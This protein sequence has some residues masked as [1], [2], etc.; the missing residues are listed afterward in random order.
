[1]AHVLNSNIT[2][3]AKRI[4]LFTRF[5]AVQ[6]LAQALGLAAG[7]IIVRTLDKGDYALYTL[8]ISG[9][10]VGKLRGQF[11]P[12]AHRSAVSRLP[13]LYNPGNAGLLLLGLFGGSVAVAD[14][15]A[16][17][18]IAAFF[19]MFT[20]A[21][22]SLVLPRYARCKNPHELHRLY[23]GAFVACAAVALLP[24]ITA[25]I[26]PQPLLWILGTKY[27]NLSHELFLVAL[28]SGTVFLS[29]MTWGLNSVRGWIVPSWIMVSASLGSLVIF[30]QI[31]GVSTMHQVL[32]V[33][34][35]S[36]VVVMFVNILATLIFFKTH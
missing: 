33:G 7:F 25:L 23:L 30:M 15:G 35:L 5:M 32:W 6:A 36:S 13:S 3:L 12:T 10:H 27:Q 29:E 11:E 1:M 26:I 9:T 14:F 2:A 4:S 28:S 34:I 20:A 18:R 16:L 8:T 24:V 31:I 21:M 22:Q 17:G 19:S